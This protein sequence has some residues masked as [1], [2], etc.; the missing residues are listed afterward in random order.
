MKKL[1]RFLVVFILLTFMLILFSTQKIYASS[2]DS[3]QKVEYSEDFKKWLELS[4]EEKTNTLMPR[5][6][7]ISYT[8]IISKNPLNVARLL[9]S[10]ANP[11]YSLRDII[12]ENLAIR[13]QQDTNLCW[14]FATLSSLETNLALY[15]YNRGINTDK[16]YD[17]SERHM[18]YA[19]SKTFANDV[20]NPLGY[21]KEVGS[22][23]SYQ[24]AQSYLT[25]GSGA[26]LE[27]DMPFENNENI[28]D[29][30]QIQ[31]K[32]ISSQVY[33]TI[34]FPDYQT[35]TG[36]EKTNIMN[37]IKEHIQNYGGVQGS[38][39]GNSS[40]VSS[41]SCYNN[42]TGAKYCNNTD[43][44]PIDHAISIIGWD[45]NYSVDNFTESN[46]PS[47]NGAWIAR[48]S[49][50]DKI[51]YS[52]LEVKQAI[53]NAYKNQEIGKDWTSAEDVPDNLVESNG[54]TIDGDIAYIPYGDNGFIYVSYEDVNISKN[55]FGIV[56]ASDTVDYDNIYQYD[57]YFPGMQLNAPT[58]NILLGNIFNKESVG[59]EYLTQISLYAP[60]TYTC[61]VYV[62]PNGTSFSKDDLKQVSL[63][64]GETETFSTGYHTL[65]FAKPI[66]I[67]S[68]SFSVVVEI[69]STN[70]NS[71]KLSLESKIPGLS[72]WDSVTTEKGKCFYSFGNNLD[73]A[74]WV[75]IGTLH[76]MNSSFSNGDSTIKAFTTNEL[77]DGSLKNIEIITPP[78]KTSY[79]EGENFDSTGMVVQ[80]NYNSKTNPSSILDSSSYN[81]TNGTN[82]KASQTSV[83][84]SYQD[85]TATQAIT[86]KENNVTEL[87][88]KTPPTKTEYKEGENFDKTGMVI[89]AT[90]A[91]G[92]IK[93]ISDYTITNGNNLKSGQT[94]ITITYQDK[95]ITQTI[96][97]TS[98]PLIEIQVSKEPNKTS[99]VAGQDFDKTGMVITGI[100]EDGSEYEII[101]Y[102]IENGTNLSIGQT[103]VTI[104]FDG[105]TTTQS[106]SVEEKKITKIK[107]NKVPSK[108]NYIQY[109][110]D[111]DLTGGT[112]LVNYNDNSS[113]E[114]SLTSDEI[115][116]TGFDNTT[117]GKKTITI[118][119]ESY[120]ATFDVEIVEEITAVNSNFDNID[121]KVTSARYYTFSDKNEE[122]YFVID[123][124][125]DGI[126]NTFNNDSYEYYY[127][128]SPNQNET[129]IQDWVKITENNTFSSALN[130]EINTKDIKNYADISDADTLY[131][132]IKE[133][134]ITGG[135]QSVLVPKPMEITPDV[136]VQVYLDNVILDNYG[137]NNNGNTNNNNNT[138][139][140][141]N[142]N[143]NNNN[144]AQIS[145]LPKAGIKTILILI[146]LFSTTSIIVYI[147]YKNLKKYIK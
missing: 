56:K 8:N 42:S 131:L 77:E 104:S 93:E 106:I 97:V 23:G 139:N 50:G 95:T 33:D 14:A 125:I 70:Q 116:V 127:Y 128:L 47:S 62:N 134:A 101:D 117:L 75:D 10:T 34:S 12:P 119:Y 60:E 72:T 108:T 140:N 114:I 78:N 54:Y 94:E 103:S 26:V 57:Y 13:N 145:T 133:V 129:N 105:K 79:F 36:E 92:T 121:Y 63:K 100:Y 115:S 5:M 48:N 135:S 89:E 51:E 55:M 52:V 32:N 2:V 4:E 132:Y 126:E 112:I 111:L 82:L 17:F 85:K 24:I 1:K 59:T 98:N 147:R 28:I 91:D 146:L 69:Q 6:F 35:A 65:E 90:Y 99:Y 29:I 25:N 7:N 37:Q 39:H 84:I 22:G 137:S 66:E 142:N 136:T 44:H 110:E 43:L 49:W 27:S 11:K 46:K 53:F 80:A 107:V 124:S 71:I 19:T 76:D 83:T 141:A 45:D 118:N 61:K 15:N 9:K 120:T 30:S 96:Q 88:I 143:S 38:L 81:I 16:I 68:N 102:I 130:F 21:N 87:K 41:F 64:T 113:E 67:N 138:N 58:Q 74:E 3:L 122:E 73:S 31:N 18:E 109:K 123:F 86:V 144:R 40:N 20:K